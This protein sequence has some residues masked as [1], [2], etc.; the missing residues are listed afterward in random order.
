MSKISI[1][2]IGIKEVQKN[3]N[4]KNN[5]ILNAVKEAT[6]QAGFFVES[7]VVES[8]AGNRDEPRSVDTSNFMQGVKTKISDSGFTAEIVSTNAD[9]YAPILEYGSST[10]QGRY[11]FQN[12][13]S[14]NRDK[15]KEYLNN[16][17]KD[18]TKK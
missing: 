7:E 9:A 8:I 18:A 16:A 15:V 2:V 17:V 6:A 1:S 12:T 10:R 5:A 13:A 4:I 14:R 11:H 3:L